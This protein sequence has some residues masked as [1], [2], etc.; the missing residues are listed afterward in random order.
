MSGDNAG[1]R[2]H[3]DFIELNLHGDINKEV[4]S[5]DPL[6]RQPQTVFLP[7][8]KDGDHVAV[9]RTP[10]EVLYLVVYEQAVVCG[11]GTD[12]FDSDLRTRVADG[13]AEKSQ[14]WIDADSL[15]S[16]TVLYI[17]AKDHHFESIDIDV[18]YRGWKTR[19]KKWIRG[20]KLT[21]Q[22]RV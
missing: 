9:I 6:V 1:E 22:T 4:I 15:S 3:A 8:P 17:D 16:A 2:V 7:A 18:E 10:P 5:E 20:L 13:G 11:Q 19:L 21:L 12:T 14:F